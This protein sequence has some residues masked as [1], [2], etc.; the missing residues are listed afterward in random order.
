MRFLVCLVIVAVGCVV[1]LP[2]DNT[3]TADIAAETAR[4]VVQ[5]RSEL[6]P[7]P[8]P[9]SDECDNCRGTGKIGDGKIMHTC[10]SCAGTGKKPKSVC[11]NCK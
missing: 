1:T 3:V 8:A 11:I 7:T 5:M 4:M 9:D 6:R 2:Q 10:P